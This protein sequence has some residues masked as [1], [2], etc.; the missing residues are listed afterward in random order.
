MEAGGKSFLKLSQAGT[1]KLI[2]NNAQA[3]VDLQVKSKGNANVFRTDAF[4]NSVYFGDNAG[5]G[6]DNN[7][8]V[9]GSIGSKNTSTRG[10]AVFSGDVVVSGTLSDKNGGVGKVTR[11]KVDS[12]LTSATSANQNLVISGIDMSIGKFDPNYI[13]V[14]VNGQ[15]LVSGTASQITD[16]SLDYNVTGDDTLKFSFD[17]EEDDNVSIVVFPK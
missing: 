3:D 11:T 15:L 9:S 16:G 8:Y 10:T 17:I 13:D 5:A 1:N 12:R 6:V 2:I 14:F 4:N 7:F